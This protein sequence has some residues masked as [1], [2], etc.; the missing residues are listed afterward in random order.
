VEPTATVP[1]TEAGMLLKFEPI[2]EKNNL[3]NFY[4]HQMISKNAI[5]PNHEFSIHT[6]PKN[7]IKWSDEL[8]NDSNFLSTN[9]NCVPSIG[10]PCL[11]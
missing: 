2:I 6:Q 3:N 5:A 9:N 4:P 10:E 7:L 11:D 8:S 1:Y